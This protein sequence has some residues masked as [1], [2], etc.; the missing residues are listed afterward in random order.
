[1]L[2][3]LLRKYLSVLSIF[4]EIGGGVFGGSWERMHYSP[5]FKLLFILKFSIECFLEDELSLHYVGCL[6]K[7]VHTSISNILHIVSTYTICVCTKDI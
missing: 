2:G 3:G 7:E 5:P 1:M 6:F 4:G